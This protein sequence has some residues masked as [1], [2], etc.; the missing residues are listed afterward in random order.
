MDNDRNSYNSILKAIGLFGGVKVFQIVVGIVKNKLVAI[1]LGPVGM[2]IVG[3]LTSTTSLIGT[4]T[5]LGLSTSTVRDISVAYSTGDEYRIGKVVSILKKLVWATGILGALVT[6]LF[7]N[8]LSIWAFGNEDYATAFKILSILLIIDQLTIGKTALMQ[9]T[10]HYKYMAQASLY[11]SVLGLIIS[12]PLYYQWG[13]N[14]I[15]PVI[16]LSS[17][18]SLIL[19]CLYARKIRITTVKVS[20][21]DIL[22]DG[23]TMIVLGVVL[24]ATSA[25]RLGGTYIQRAFVSN[26]G[27]IADVGLFVAGSAIV[28]QYIDVILGAMSNDYTPRLSAISKEN[29]LFVETINRQM[30]LMVTITV[31]FILLFLIFGKEL[32]LILYTAEFLSIT[33][34]I[35]WMM[36]SMFFRAISWCLSF[37]FVAKGESKSFFWNETICTIYS[38]LF[39]IAGYYFAGFLGLGLAFLITYICYTM[40]MVVLAMRTFDFNFSKDC[41]NLIVKHGVCLM[42]SFTIIQ[43]LDYSLWKYVAGM[44]A[45]LVMCYMSYIDLNKMISVKDVIR[46]LKNKVFHGKN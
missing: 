39:S 18:A 44:L 42:I 43:M 15:V 46:G 6:L 9:G 29:E 27:S 11:G 12:V 19:S 8:Y 26:Y 20:L 32:I 40:Q 25:F 28:T 36:L 30:K 7:S 38:L 16:I 31:P 2:G 37:S 4:F 23:R 24:A 33:S 22:T 14:A 21:R 41:L 1:L 3:M 10:F 35:E 17:F 5:G 13:N 45:L 34:M